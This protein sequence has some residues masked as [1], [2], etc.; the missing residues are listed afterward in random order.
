MVAGGYVHEKSFKK[1]DNCDLFVADVSLCYKCSQNEKMSPNPNVMVELGY[2]AK[3][4][5][6]ERIICIANE[7]YGKELP[8]DV[9]HNRVIFYSL[10]KQKARNINGNRRQETLTETGEKNPKVTKSSW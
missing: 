7:D 1:I 3:V 4:L 8:F 2:A 9:A 5:G 10:G 6:W